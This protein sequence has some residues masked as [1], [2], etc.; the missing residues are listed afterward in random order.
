LLKGAHKGLANSL[1]ARG[2]TPLPIYVH[3]VN[4]ELPTVL[5]HCHCS[6]P[7]KISFLEV[8]PAQEE[9]AETA[10]RSKI[11]FWKSNRC[12]GRV[13]GAWTCQTL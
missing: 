7:L 1:E 11:H 4:T 9:C 2:L 5:F 13:R 8:I 3:L 10:L 6:A 12:L